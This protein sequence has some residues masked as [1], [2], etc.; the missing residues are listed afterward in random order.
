MRSNSFHASI[1][2]AFGERAMSYAARESSGATSTHASGMMC[3]RSLDDVALAGNCGEKLSPSSV[4]RSQQPYCGRAG[5]IAHATEQAITKTTAAQWQHPTGGIKM[6]NACTSLGIL[7]NGPKSTD[8]GISATPGEAHLRN[9]HDKTSAGEP[10]VSEKARKNRDA[11]S[12]NSH[13]LII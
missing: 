7:P 2:D 3:C 11:G 8:L 13:L 9:Q 10:S 4:H 1:P 5:S 6:T 12:C